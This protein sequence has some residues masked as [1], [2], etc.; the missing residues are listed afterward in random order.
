MTYPLIGQGAI[1]AIVFGVEVMVYK[2]LQA[3]GDCDQSP[4]IRNSVIAGFC[5]GSV[6]T[7]IVSPMELI[8]IR[9]QTQNIGQQHM[10]WLI[11]EFGDIPTANK[12]HLHSYSGPVQ[13]TI[14]ITRREG[15]RGLFKGW[16]LTYFREAPQFGIY[17][18]T[19]AWVR[20]KMAAFANT[21][22]DQL[23]VLPLSL[24]GGITGVVTWL[25]YPVDVIKSR[26]QNDGAHLTKRKYTGMMDCVKK[27]VKHEGMG[28]FVK[29]IQPT[30]VRGFVNGFVTLPIFT[31]TMYWLD[32]KHV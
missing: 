6:Q 3:P 31:L 30:L 10:A 13:T 9:M 26:Y 8:K 23:G 7:V 22:P 5:A 14:E 12:R 1:N 18:G 20:T 19:Y 25:W 15:I 24:A 28:V 27:S 16:W 4:N 17:F 21:S 29:G 11:K 32:G 2:R